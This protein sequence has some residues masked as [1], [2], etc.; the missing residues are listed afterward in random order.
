MRR[1]DLAK[2]VG[3][4]DNHR[5]STNRSNSQ[6]STPLVK[7]FKKTWTH[8]KSKLM[9]S[10]RGSR[11]VLWWRILTTADNTLK[12]TTPLTNSQSIRSLG[13]F[14]ELTLTRLQ[15]KNCVCRS[16]ISSWETAQSSIFRQIL[17]S[18][19]RSL[20]NNKVKLRGYKKQIKII[21]Q[22]LSII[23][24]SRNLSCLKN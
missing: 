22:T 6:A 7:Y 12:W 14:R 1:N 20:R 8:L 16:Q 24:A 4:S 11:P 17:Q 9:S 2:L 19:R 23:Q 15:H 13:P 5:W 10:S 21:P 18:T 3:F